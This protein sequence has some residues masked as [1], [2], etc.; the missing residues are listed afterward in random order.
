MTSQERS[1]SSW[2]GG[3]TLHNARVE[4]AA[5]DRNWT[6]ALGVSN[7]TDKVYYLNIFDLTAFGEPTIWGQPGAPRQ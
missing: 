1:V 6:A 2:A 3:Y 5:N 4:Y 7:L